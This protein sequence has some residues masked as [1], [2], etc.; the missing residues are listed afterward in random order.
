MARNNT[1]RVN[2][3]KEIQKL[4]LKK[5]HINSFSMQ[6]KICMMYDDSQNNECTQYVIKVCDKQATAIDERLKQLKNYLQIVNY[7]I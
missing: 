1:A 6:M 3:N 4:E 7:M 2:L 5:L